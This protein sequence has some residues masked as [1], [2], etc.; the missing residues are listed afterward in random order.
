MKANKYDKIK[1]FIN[2]I[3][4]TVFLWYHTINK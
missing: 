1:N 3:D 4:K 2:S